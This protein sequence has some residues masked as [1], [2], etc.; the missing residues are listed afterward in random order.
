VLQEPV[1]DLENWSINGGWIFKS[2]SKIHVYTNIGSAWRAPAVNELYSDGLHHGTASIEKGNAALKQERCFNFIS[3]LV[4][5]TKFIEADISAYSNYFKDFIYLMP[6]KQPELTI[7][8]AF[9]VFYYQQSDALIS[10]IDYKI[11]ILIAKHIEW[12]TKGMF[13]RGKNLSTKDWLVWMPSDRAQSTLTYIFNSG[14]KQKQTRI[15]INAEYITKQWRVPA[16][17]DYAPPP[18]GYFL[19][20]ADVSS[21]LLVKQQE[22]RIGINCSNGLNTIY[23]DYLDRFRY[24]T[25]A[26]GIN[27]QF[28]L[29]IPFTLI[30]IKNNKL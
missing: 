10:G 8:G 9:P 5:R 19:L 18:K 11:K 13:L 27:I 29:Q 26:Q 16:N 2:D 17:S 1:I 30:H 23:R 21:T 14:K 6:G 24:Y 7:K 12:E 3:T 25:D 28:R 22:I 4:Y 20:G 15:G